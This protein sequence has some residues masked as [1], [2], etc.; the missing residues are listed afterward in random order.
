MKPGDLV[1][2]DLPALE[3][4]M[5]SLGEKRYHA[6]QI[7]RWIYSRR[8]D[9]FDGMTDLSRRTRGRL[10]EAF[11]ARRPRV[12]RVQESS[13]GTRKYLLEGLRG[14]KIEA[15]AIPE[16]RRVTFCISPQ[17]G[18]ALDCH[19]CLTASMGLVRHLEPGEIVGQVLELIEDNAERIGSRPVNIVMMGMGEALHNYDNSMAAVRLLADPQGVAIP[20]RRITLSTAGMVPGILRLASEKVRPRLAIS[21]NATTDEVRSRIMPINKRYP[22]ATLM[23]ACRSYPLGARER[24][25]FEYVLLGGVNDT[26]DDPARLVSLVGRHAIKAKINL[27]PFN[28]AAGLGYVE[29]QES[30]VRRFR[31]HLLAHGLPVSI[32]K[33]RG[34]DI[35]AACGQLAVGP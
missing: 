20:A 34:R 32:R 11:S 18:C 22:L 2:L 3:R 27:I 12:A 25:T 19:F 29:P 8:V 13:D 30:S 35:S 28:P 7:Y 15:V 23:D 10:A 33:N 1:G 16:P 5:E 31:D 24:L 6:S 17:I 14:G 9:S 21:L 4:V 26:P